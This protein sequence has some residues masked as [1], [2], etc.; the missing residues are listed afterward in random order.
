MLISLD[1]LTV[2]SFSWGLGKMSNNQAESYSLLKACQ[3]AKETGFKYLHVYGDSKILIKMLNSDGLFNIPA[4]NVILKRIRIILKDFEKVEFFHILRAL[5]E[6]VDSLANVACLLSQ[7]YLSL[8][9]ETS[10][11]QPIP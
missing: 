8:N 7:G 9:G 3:L 1:R 6:T 10:L 4:L 11:F 5:N 2:T